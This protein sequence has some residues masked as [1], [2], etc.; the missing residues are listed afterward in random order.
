MATLVYQEIRVGQLLR[1]LMM[2]AGKPILQN[3]IDIEHQKYGSEAKI[4][5]RKET[6]SKIKIAT[7]FVTSRIIIIMYI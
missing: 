4:Y 1:S 3:K 7:K 6:I 5:K 2:P